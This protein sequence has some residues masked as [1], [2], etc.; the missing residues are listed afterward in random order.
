MKD[1]NLIEEAYYEL[2]SRAVFFHMANSH[3]TRL[4]G[5]EALEC[6]KILR[7]FFPA[8]PEAK[9]VE[10]PGVEVTTTNEHKRLFA[11]RLSLLPALQ[12]S[13]CLPVSHSPSDKDTT[14]AV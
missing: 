14:L 9:G 11:E 12:K 4:R 2:L 3:G 10:L 8:L 7:R 5:R 6:A 1:E 13:Q